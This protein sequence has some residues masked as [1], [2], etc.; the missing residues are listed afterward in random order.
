MGSFL[1][2]VA[3]AF[4]AALLFTGTAFAAP[5]QKTGSTATGNDVSYPQCGRSLPSGQAF[6]V[7]DGLANTTNPCLAKEITWAQKS[8]G[9]TSQPPAS[10]YV[11][12]ANPGNLGVADCRPTTSIRLPGPLSL[13]LRHL[14]PR[15]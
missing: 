15:R 14:C 13:I 7:N 6:G 3:A 11:N 10:L 8:T 12:T 1:P 2:A 5:Y 9:T 4:G